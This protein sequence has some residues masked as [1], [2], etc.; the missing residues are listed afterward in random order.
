MSAGNLGFK[1]PGAPASAV[2]GVQLELQPGDRL[3]LLGH[4][5]CGKSTLLRLL[6]GLYQPTTGSV[7]V[8]DL[9]MLQIDPAHLRSHFGYVGQDAQLFM[10]TLRDNLVLTDTWITDERIR[11]VLSRLGLQKLVASHPR[12]LDMPL[13][14]SGGGLSGGQRQLLTIARMMLR[15]PVYVFMDEP[16]ANLDQDTET[17][18]IT[19]LG[20]WLAGRTLVVATHRPQLLSLVNQLAIMRGGQVIKQGARDDILRELTENAKRR[21][22]QPGSAHTSPTDQNQA[23]PA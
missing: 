3:A 1:Y 10:G 9:D 12:G 15:D 23:S 19:L 16:T 2:E 18:V 4:V 13:T 5:G 11:D 22:A 21:R 7:K 20:Q 8:D 17:A 14:E 6:S